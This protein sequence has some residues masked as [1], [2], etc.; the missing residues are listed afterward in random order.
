MFERDPITEV[1]REYGAMAA[2]SG[3]VTNLS[4]MSSGY[5]DAARENQQQQQAQQTSSGFSQRRN[6]HAID[7]CFAY[8][9][10]MLY[11]II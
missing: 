8:F 10:C 5:G 11:L 4:T 7:E 3:A 2:A 1:V 6:M 9:F